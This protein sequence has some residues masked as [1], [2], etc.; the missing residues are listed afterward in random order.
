ML[1]DRGLKKK[2]RLFPSQLSNTEIW[3]KPR[4]PQSVSK[5]S[6]HM[7]ILVFLSYFTLV[8]FPQNCSVKAVGDRCLHSLSFLIMSL[9]CRGQYQDVT[10]A[11]S[12]DRVGSVYWQNTWESGSLALSQSCLHLHRTLD[13][14]PTFK[15]KSPHPWKAGCGKDNHQGSLD[16]WHWWVRPGLVSILQFRNLRE[17]QWKRGSEVI[18]IQEDIVEWFM[19]QGL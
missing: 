12:P 8:W 6:H 13:K 15:A 11:Q 5:H 2:K 9:S 3:K 7:H 10:V 19:P 17:G 16:L 14:S 4:P 1:K 18:S